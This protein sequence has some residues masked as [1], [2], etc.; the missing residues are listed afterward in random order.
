MAPGEKAAKSQ[1]PMLRPAKRADLP[2]VERLLIAAALP[3]VGVADALH[4]FVVAD[5]GSEIVGVAGLEV[6]LENGLLR[7]LAVARSWQ[8]QGLARALVARVTTIAEQR[9][10]IALYLLTTTAADYFPRLGFTVLTRDRVPADIAGT[11]EFRSACPS[12]ATVMVRPITRA[13]KS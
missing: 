1:T 8:G 13:A 5:A 6:C 11:E 10:L 2:P 4:D 7:S 9:R 3:T 12:S